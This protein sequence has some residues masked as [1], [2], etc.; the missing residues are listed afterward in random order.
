MIKTL[1][2]LLL[3]IAAPLAAGAPTPAR[4]SVEESQRLLDDAR[5]RLEQNEVRAAIIQLRNAILEDDGNVEARR[6]LGEL[7]LRTGQIEAATVEL[8]RA[9]EAEPSAATAVLAA[10]AQLAMGRPAEALALLDRHVG[11]DDG[12]A[13]ALVRG[14]VLLALDRPEEVAQAAARALEAAPLDPAANLLEARRLAALGEYDAARRRAAEVV[15]LAPDDLE[16]W[17]LLG[18]L[19]LAGFDLDAAERAAERATALAPQAP[20]VTLFRAE[21][22]ARRGDSEAARAAV[23]TVLA[24]QPENAAALLQLARLQAEAGEVDAADRTLRP[25]ADRLRYDPGALLLQGTLKARLGRH[26]QARELLARYLAMRPENRSVRHLLAGLALVDDVPGQAIEALA[27]V[28]A[29]VARSQDLRGLV[30]LSSAQLRLD[31]YDAARR[32]L[33][34]ITAFDGAEEARQAATLFRLLDASRALDPAL[35]RELVLAVDAV[36]LD[37]LDVALA[38]AR[39]AT[40]HPAAG[41]ESRVVLANVRIARGETEAGRELFEAVLAEEPGNVGA[42]RGLSRL[43]YVGGDLARVEERLR[44]WLERAPESDA[45][46]A[47]MIRF[48]GAQGRLDE[49]RAL[50]EEQRRDRPASPFVNRTLAAVLVGLDDRAALTALAADIAGEVEG[51]A[52]ALAPF[53]GGLFLRLGAPA[54][55]AAVLET[56]RAER[57]GDLALLLALA[58]A[59]YLLDDEA[60]ARE[61]LAD[62]LERE[63]TNNIAATS[64]VDLDLAAGDPESALAFARGLAEVNRLF[65][66]SLESRVRFALGEPEAAVAVLEE[67]ATAAPGSTAARLVFEARRRAGRTEAAT[68][69]LRQWVREHPTDVSNLNLLSQ[70]LIARA[71]DT[72]DYEEAAALLE[73]AIQLVP[74]DPQLLNNLAWLRQ[75]TGRPGAET[76]ARRALLRAPNSPQ[77]ADTLGWILAQKGDLETAVPLLRAAARR[78][79]DNPDIRYHLAYALHASGETAEAAR[80]LEEVLA[81]DADFMNRADAEALRRRLEQG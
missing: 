39:T 32:T 78:A 81:S 71:T 57:P 17:L 33:A 46:L 35:R 51:G 8:R 49:A 50:L 36:R 58:R 15:D 18:R 47:D 7:Y 34:R 60:A 74:S 63:P 68:A 10:Q 56:A 27:D 31:D 43:E 61:L 29:N 28:R 62:V 80:I 59:R 66:A 26:A 1:L 16:G 42:L 38:H 44:A 48:L 24:A 41:T 64:L 11:E 79:A 40:L 2:A 70:V 3:L 73:R 45:A 6:L 25:I 54:E 30:L 67:A 52:A 13:A 77:I 76:L 23:E 37:R 21:L 12:L 55:A 53:A 75:R 20:A 69:G 65:A 22:A 4:A 72:Q 19:H 9:L 14:R 5:S